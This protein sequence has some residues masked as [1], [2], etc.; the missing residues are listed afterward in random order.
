VIDRKR[1]NAEAK[2]CGVIPAP[3]MLGQPCRL[4]HIQHNQML[5]FP[6]YDQQ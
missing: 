5:I 4:H 6:A 1:A 2:C 3:R